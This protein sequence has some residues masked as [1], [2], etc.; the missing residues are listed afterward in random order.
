MR[1][2][3]SALVVATIL[4]GAVCAA[5]ASPASSAPIEIGGETWASWHDYVTSEAFVD[6]GR[7]CGTRPA[8]G[9]DEILRGAASDCALN[10]TNPLPEYDPGAPFVLTL[11]FH[12]ITATNGNGNVT[13][14]LI[15]SQVDILNEDYLAMAGTNGGNGNDAAI[16][17]RLATEDPDG[18]PTNGITRTVNNSWY[19]DAG[20]YY[21]TLAWDPARYVN[22]YTNSAGGYLGYVPDLPQSGTL[23]GTNADR[24]VV[25]WSAVGRDAPI[26]PPYDQ[27]RTLTHEMGHYLGLWHT[28]ANGCGSVGA[29]YTSGD[30]I[31][32]TDPESSPT[33]GCPTSLVTCGYPVPKENYMDYS[34]DLCMEWFT[35][36]QVRRMRCTLQ[37]WRPDLSP[38]G[39]VGANEPFAAGA[40]RLLG[41]NRPNP[42]GTDTRIAYDLPRSGPVSL[43]VLDV[44]GRT[45]RTLV[46]GVREAGTHGVA[47]DGRDAAGAPVAAGVYFYRL[48]AP[49][50]AETRR[51]VKLD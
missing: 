10:S 44:A 50:G 17:F 28:F 32:D 25:L 7:R 9:T 41:Q 35:T 6:G 36:E 27:G 2:W 45:V 29:C 3:L 19:N 39:A 16:Q 5:P 26:G 31:C 46:S 1:S 30:R 37:Y 23:V 14:A 51:M 18:N 24:I 40:I 12:V 8:G 38:A 4:P 21:N 11:V 15:E 34:D 49:G 33:Y 42:F 20:T 22:V 13:D 43:R 47:W 48:Q